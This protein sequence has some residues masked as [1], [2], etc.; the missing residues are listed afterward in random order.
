[1]RERGRGD[2][3]RIFDA[4]T[5]MHLVALFEA[6]QDRNRILDR[7]LAHK[8]DLEPALQSGVFFNVLAVFVERGGADGAQLAP[9][10]RWLQHVAGINRAFGRACP[11]QGM[12]FVNEQDDLAFRLFNLF[13]HRLEPIFEFTAVLRTRQHR[14]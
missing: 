8:S 9:G 4:D 14:T 2:N 6:T 13:Q 5:V 1:M 10:Q 7:G 11:Y 12:Q 3:R